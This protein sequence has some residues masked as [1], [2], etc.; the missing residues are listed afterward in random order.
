MEHQFDFAALLQAHALLLSGALATVGLAAFASVVGI[1]LSIGGA[2]LG[3][4]GIKAARQVVAG[5]VE[6]IRNTPFLVQMFFIFFGLPTLGLH[7]NAMQAAALAMTINLSAYSIEIV[8]AGIEAVPQGQREAG[9]AL[10]LRPV[11][12]FGKIV[13]PQALGS[14]WPALVSQVVIIL[15][16]S[17]VVSQIAVRDLTYAGDVIQS[18]TFRPFETYLIITAIYLI[19]AVAA[20]R[21]LLLLGRRLF[22]SGVR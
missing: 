22:V 3:R 18:R 9:M 15:L 20:R 17:A 6:L 12:V 8:R 5:Y 4:S 14:M 2:A 13:L 7:L 10:G 21:V 1:C 19:L 16:E 11:I